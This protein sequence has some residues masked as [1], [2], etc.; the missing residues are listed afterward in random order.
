M[1][2]NWALKEFEMMGKT[3]TDPR[4]V[5]PNGGGDGGKLAKVFMSINGKQL[6][7]LTLSQLIEMFKTSR[8]P[9][10]IN[11]NFLTHFQLL[12]SCHEACKCFDLL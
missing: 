10:S 8:S 11:V 2:I 9:A 5:P 12:K 1:W 7:G 4:H 6:I 3:P